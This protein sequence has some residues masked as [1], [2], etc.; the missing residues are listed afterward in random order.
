MNNTIITLILVVAGSIISLSG[1]A[2]GVWIMTRYTSLFM[3][4]PVETIIPD[5]NYPG[6][7]IDS[8][9]FEPERVPWED[10][11]SAPD[12]DPGNDP[13]NWDGV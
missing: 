7:D 4:S 13:D 3:G 2:V 6:A 5:V 11:P 9:P 8:G 10:E 12:G 1:V